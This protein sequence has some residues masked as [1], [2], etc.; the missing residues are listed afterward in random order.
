MDGRFLSAPSLDLWREGLSRIAP[1][2]AAVAEHEW[3]SVFEREELGRALQP[4]TPLR[5]RRRL[6][7]AA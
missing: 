7:M 5:S 2:R 6:P 1:Q 3:V 4:E